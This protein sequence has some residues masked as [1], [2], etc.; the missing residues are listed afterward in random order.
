MA[1]LGALLDLPDTELIGLCR[2]SL[3]LVVRASDVPTG[4]AEPGH[5]QLGVLLA[6]IG[7]RAVVNGWE[8][9]E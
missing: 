2:S 6:E 8:P 5:D 3:N 4:I 1:S 9:A 7:R